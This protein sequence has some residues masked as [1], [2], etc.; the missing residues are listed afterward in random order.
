LFFFL[1]AFIIFIGLLT[2][3]FLF[4][5]RLDFAETTDD[6]RINVSD[7]Q[8]VFI[9]DI[10]IIGSTFMQNPKHEE[11]DSQIDYCTSNAYLNGETPIDYY[12]SD[13]FN[14]AQD[15]RFMCAKEPLNEETFQ[16][17]LYLIL[18]D[19]HANQEKI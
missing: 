8:N 19:F 16:Y 2:H 12:M 17:H 9:I 10:R 7:I 15:I 11:D 14:T 5:T 4:N 13:Y 6:D 18:A 1:W 3:F